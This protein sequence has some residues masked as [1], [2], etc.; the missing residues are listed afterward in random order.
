MEPLLSV[1]PLHRQRSRSEM[2]AIDRGRSSLMDASSEAMEALT[3]HPDYRRAMNSDHVQ[4]VPGRGYAPLR[5]MMA[6][7]A[8]SYG[9]PL[10]PQAGA[11]ASDDMLPAPIA[12]LLNAYGAVQST[13][14]GALAGLSS[15]TADSQGMADPLLRGLSAWADPAADMSAVHGRLYRRRD[16]NPMSGVEA[17]A[18]QVV[19]DPLAYVGSPR[20]IRTE[21]VDRHGDVIRSLRNAQPAPRLGLPAPSY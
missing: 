19:M 2:D 5:E 7:A 13:A 15:D 6:E 20:G 10:G 17:F 1:L 21:L 9:R 12:G 8:V 4:F 18:A 16:G 11:M 3:G 14:E